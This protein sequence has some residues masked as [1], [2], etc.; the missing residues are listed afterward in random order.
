MDTLIALACPPHGHA[1]DPAPKGAVPN[2]ESLK[3][4]QVIEPIRIGLSLSEIVGNGA[5]NRVVRAKGGLD[6]KFAVKAV[7]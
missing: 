4:F 2:E 3:H 6:Q 1:I 7:S 5:N